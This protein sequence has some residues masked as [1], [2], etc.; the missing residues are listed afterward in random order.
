MTATQKEK[1]ARLLEEK[2][3][4]LELYQDTK[5]P[6]VKIKTVRRLMKIYA[7]QLAACL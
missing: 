6:A 2:L 5:C 7:R 1:R 3:A 4:Q